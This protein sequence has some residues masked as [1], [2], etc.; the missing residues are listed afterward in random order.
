MEKK[1]LTKNKGLNQLIRLTLLIG[2]MGIAT[3]LTGCDGHGKPEE[4]KAYEEKL[5]QVLKERY[6]EA[7]EITSMTYDWNLKEYQFEVVSKV[8][9]YIHS[10]GSAPI[11]ESVEEANFYED[12]TSAYIEGQ[13]KQYFGAKLKTFFP[14]D[15]YYCLLGSLNTAEPEWEA[16]YIDLYKDFKHKKPKLATI[17]AE[18]PEM[19]Y[20]NEFIHV[21]VDIDKV[22]RE[23]LLKKTYSYF[24]AHKD[25]KM[26]EIDINIIFIDN[27]VRS[28]WD[29]AERYVNAQNLSGEF[30][31]IERDLYLKDLYFVNVPIP[32]GYFDELDTYESF[33][34]EYKYILTKK[35]GD[36]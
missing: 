17:L 8:A 16:Y 28:L 19:V 29:P 9:P 26:K 32:R 3:L 13:M 23:E 36:H 18:K 7:F 22:D 31:N 10:Y 12:Y 20:M 33:K 25:L 15:L 34:E 5:L 4:Q 6:D 1:P 14:T 2:L 21:Y 30:D 27:S 11:A 35:R 24:R